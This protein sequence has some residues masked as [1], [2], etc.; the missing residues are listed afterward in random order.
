MGVFLMGRLQA[1]RLALHVAASGAV[2]KCSY[3][4]TFL[5]GTHLTRAKTSAK[6][7][8]ESVLMTSSSFCS[9]GEVNTRRVHIVWPLQMSTLERSQFYPGK[10][11]K[12]LNLERSDSSLLLFYF[13]YQFLSYSS[14]AAGGLDS[15]IS[16]GPFQPLQFYDSPH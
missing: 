4:V 13:L 10:K 5:G 2:R 9:W 11:K 6:S 15:I 12:V 14:T 1:A 8:S 7:V 3:P 16:G